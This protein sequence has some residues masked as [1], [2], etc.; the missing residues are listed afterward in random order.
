M[1]QD[2]SSQ[3]A[4]KNYVLSF[5]RL[6]PTNVFAEAVKTDT[7]IE[8]CIVLANQ[9]YFVVA[10]RENQITV[11]IIDVLSNNLLVISVDK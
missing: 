7:N 9:I 11:S 2:F 3:G 4:E 1:P 6:V 8:R 10:D 5:R